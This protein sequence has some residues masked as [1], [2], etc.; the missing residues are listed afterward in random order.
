LEVKEYSHSGFSG[1]SDG[2]EFARSAG[3]T[4]KDGLIPGLR[5]PPGEGNGNLL[6]YSCW[7]NSIDRG[8]CGLQS[9]GLQRVGHD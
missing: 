4:G 6:Q 7:E 8:T 5:R 1:G 9:M 3:G 2:K